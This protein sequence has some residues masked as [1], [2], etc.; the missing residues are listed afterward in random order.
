MIV[1][2]IV[3]SK[4]LNASKLGKLTHIAKLLGHI[5]AEAWRRYG[6]IGGVGRTFFDI[7]NEWMRSGRK[8]DV[9]ARLWQRQK[10]EDL[11]SI[12][13]MQVFSLYLLFLVMFLK[14]SFSLKTSV[15]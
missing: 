8:F 5:R 15:K 14:V 1:T 4:G 9:P 2:R 10:Y 12:L 6:S 11:S 7:R 3:N 13:M